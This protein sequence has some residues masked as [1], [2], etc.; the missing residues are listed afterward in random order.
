[1]PKA[2]LGEMRPGWAFQVVVTGSEGSMESDSL[3]VREVRAEASEWNFGGGSD[4]VE[5]P[6]ILDLLVPQGMSQ[7]EVLAWEP[8]SR[9]EIHASAFLDEETGS[10][11]VVAINESAQEQV[12]ELE[13]P[14][15]S[16]SLLLTPFRTAEDEAL[17]QGR[18]FPLVR[19]ADGLLRGT[20]ALAPR[21]ITTFTAPWG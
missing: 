4:G 19:A 6:N 20:I 8:A 11:V 14:H 17:A 21:S 13:L 16:R 10:L 18:R 5:D 2:F 12:V 1:M 9:V 7:A 15:E 3:R